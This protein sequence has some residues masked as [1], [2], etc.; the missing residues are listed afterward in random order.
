[1]LVA[2]AVAISLNLALAQSANGVYDAD[3]DGLIE[4]SNLEQL[5]AVRHDMDG[6][7]RPGSNATAYAQAFPTRSNQSVCESGCK[8]Y[9]LVRS[10]DFD[11]AG[12]YASGRVNPNWTEG[13]GW[14]PIGSEHY[15]G[16]DATLDGNGHTISNLYVGT[17]SNHSYSGLFG[18]AEGG[19][20]G[21]IQLADAEVTGGS[22]VGGLVGYNKGATITDSSVSGRVSG[23]AN[24][25]GLVGYNEGATI[26]DSSVSGRVSGTGGHIGG[27]VGYNDGT[28]SLS[29]ST[30]D[31]TGS[32]DVGGLA[33]YTRGTV[34][35]SY[36]TGTVTGHGDVGGLAGDLSDGTI[37]ES[38]SKSDVTGS[39][40]H[41]GG[42]VGRTWET[43]SMTSVYATGAVYGNN[44]V[45][46]LVGRTEGWPTVSMTSVYATGAVYGNNQVGGLVGNNATVSS[47]SFH[48]TNSYA[49]GS[50]SG[51]TDVGGLFG[52][53]TSGE[54]LRS[55]W[56][57]ATSGQ[58][59][60]DGGEGKSTAELR[61]PTGA[62]GIYAGWNP[63][64]WDFGSRSQYPALRADLDGDGVA[65]AGEFGGQ[66]RGPGGGV[67][68]TPTREPA[69][70]YVDFSMGAGHLCLLRDDGVV[71]CAGD[72][73]QG[74]ATPPEGGRYVA[75]DGGD[76]HT[77]GLWED[78]EV[79]CWGSV[80]GT[81]G[82]DNPPVAPTPT[83]TPAAGPVAGP[84]PTVGPTV[85]PTQPASGSC[86]ETLS[87][88]GT[89]IGEWAAG[90]ESGERAGRYA[91][92]YAFTLAEAS[93]V[94]ITLEL[95]SG[96]ADTYLY[97]REGEARSGTA[98]EE[99]DDDGG[100]T[101]RSR[102]AAALGAGTYTIEATTYDA[103]QTGIFTLTIGGL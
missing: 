21:R 57:T 58:P 41:I 97:L 27:L 55:Y 79:E 102:I 26:T 47:N 37:I 103:G 88:N 51:T 54:I 4:I 90:C 83:P 49:V 63:R 5:D 36:S 46:G 73:G 2:A 68:P 53:S 74:Q 93:E 25:G 44:Q 6:D 86:G 77:C 19:T 28:I 52:L 76:S 30:A 17:L 23:A 24:I 43:T 35:R 40:N 1:M 8:G 33:G 50:V 101:S 78:G 99:N 100:S 16:F 72:D 14:T 15:D 39:G 11:S 84:T 29:H 32:E 69:G 38:Y 66:G 87:A 7:G 91:R 98:L 18:V 89:V 45:G 94:A 62:T 9:E 22:S 10:L 59:G 67:Q 60:S 56:D 82:K 71:E 20:I 13:A 48:L 75:L 70:R 42:L 12:S 81:F 61:G 65:T 34:S 64:S 96:Q 31:V 80:A 85:G 3:G 95:A 92:Y